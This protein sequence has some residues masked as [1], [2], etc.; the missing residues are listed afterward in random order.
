L[1]SKWV[2]LCRYTTAVKSAAFI[3]SQAARMPG[4][5]PVFA[6]HVTLAGGFECGVARLHVQQTNPFHHKT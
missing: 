6:P 2:N 1:L 3:K 5:P 4:P